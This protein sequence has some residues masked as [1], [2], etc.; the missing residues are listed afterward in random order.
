MRSFDPR[1]NEAEH[2]GLK[3]RPQEVWIVH[4]DLPEASDLVV[5]MRLPKELMVRS[6]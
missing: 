4:I 3:G 1:S 6:Y 2:V 5:H